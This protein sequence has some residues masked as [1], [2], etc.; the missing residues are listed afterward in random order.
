MQHFVDFFTTEVTFFLREKRL[1][2]KFFW[3]VFSRIHTEYREIHLS[4]FSP[5]LRKYGP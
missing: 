1:Y 2:S 4:A 3:T 5:N